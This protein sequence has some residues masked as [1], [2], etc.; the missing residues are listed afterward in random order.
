MNSEIKPCDMTNAEHTAQ[1]LLDSAKGLSGI[2]F[3][4]FLL[5][6]AAKLLLA[7][8]AEIKRH[9]A[10]EP[11]KLGLRDGHKQARESGLFPEEAS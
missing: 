8:E 9:R 2:G 6:D 7:Q 4:P 11:Y 5:E 3:R 10:H 1:R